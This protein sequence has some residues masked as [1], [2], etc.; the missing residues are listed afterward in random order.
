[1]SNEKQIDGMALSQVNIDK[2][3]KTARTQ[4]EV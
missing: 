3:L 1:M 2:K 4:M